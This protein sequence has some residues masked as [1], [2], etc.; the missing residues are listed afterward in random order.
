MQQPIVDRQLEEDRAW[1]HKK[2]REFRETRR[3]YIALDFEQ[4]ELQHDCTTE[5]GMSWLDTTEP[6]SA[7]EVVT[8]HFLIS[9]YVMT[10]LDTLLE[11]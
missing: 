6:R 9:E 4:W 8:R 5:M 3:L 10:T 11:Y 2:Q 1:F 7:W